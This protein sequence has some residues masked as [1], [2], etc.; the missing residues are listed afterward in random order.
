M[1]SAMSAGRIVGALCIWLA[2]G[3]IPVFKLSNGVEYPLLGLGCASGVRKSHAISAINKGIRL[4]DTAQAYHWG[5]RED[6][7]GQAIVESRVNRSEIFVQTKLDPAYL[8]TETTRM[9]IETSMKN[10]QVE[11]LDSLL[12]HFPTCQRCQKAPEGTWL[13]SWRV[14]ED[15]YQSGRIRAIGVS[16]FDLTLLKHLNRHAVVMAHVV[17]NW[18]DPFHQDKQVRQWCQDNN[19]LYQAYSQFGGQWRHQRDGIEGSPALTNPVIRQIATKHQKT[20]S[21]VIVQWLVSLGVSA[22]PA[23][24][25]PKHQQVNIEALGFELTD[26]QI[27]Q[28]QTLDG[29][30]PGIARDGKGHEGSSEQ[31]KTTFKNLLSSNVNVYWIDQNAHYQFQSEIG[32]SESIEIGTYKGHTFVAQGED[33]EIIGRYI[34]PPNAAQ[35][36]KHTVEISSRHGRTVTDEL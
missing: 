30:M 11:Y 7:I 33:G 2:S 5:Y 8:G 22:I 36:G 25:N 28:I 24:T 19:I 16:N 23:S 21:Q 13:D 29:V 18:M 32:A 12:I 34:I 6:E 9:A 10:L 26:N 20:P 4:L 15:Y 3:T 35:N 14:M 27:Q 17:Q 1:S 31:I